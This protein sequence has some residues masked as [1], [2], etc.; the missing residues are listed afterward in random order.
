MAAPKFDYVN[1]EWQTV[2]AGPKPATCPGCS[3][4]GVLSDDPQ[5][6][7]LVFQCTSCGG[8]FTSTEPITAE[9]AMRFVALGSPMLANATEDGTFYFDLDVALVD[10][11]GHNRRHGWAD[12]KTKRVVQW[13]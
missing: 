7:R 9:Q 3:G 4:R 5:V 2:N 13:G 11:S 8:V 12:R 1:G 10:G 6:F